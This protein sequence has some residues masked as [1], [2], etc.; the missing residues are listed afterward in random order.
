V[1]KHLTNSFLDLHARNIA[2]TLPDSINALTP[3]ELYAAFGGKPFTV[4]ISK[5]PAPEHDEPAGSLPQY[6]VTAP[7]V[8]TLWAL[9]TREN[10]HPN[11]CIFD[12]TE[13]FHVP[14]D[15]PKD[16]IPGTP[17]YVAAPEILMSLPDEIN[18]S[19]DVWAFA[20]IAFNIISMDSPFYSFFGTRNMLL[21]DIMFVRGTKNV[22][23]RI[24]EAFWEKHGGKVR[25]LP[26]RE[27][28][29]D[30]FRDVSVWE[31]RT[32]ALYQRLGDDDAIVMTR[33][34]EA[35]LV[36]DPTQRATIEDIVHMIP[37][38]WGEVS[39]FA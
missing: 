32:E 34:L 17:M 15:N 2:F 25:F 10:R 5:I 1:T 3:E 13:S 39:V 16:K 29:E 23:Q 7:P 4:P 38:N 37:R 9:C 26:D 22:P 20:C 14:C 35:A 24:W 19:I 27:P 31:K 8:S 18:S 12:F 33:I 36:I 11:V 6:L 28:V 21:A 30:K